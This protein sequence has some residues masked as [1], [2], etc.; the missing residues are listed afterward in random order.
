MVYVL[1]K[2]RHY[3]SG[4]HFN[5]YTYHSSLS[6][7]LNKPLLGGRI[8]IWLLLFQ[9]SDFKVVVKSGK[10]NAGLDHLSN[11]QLPRE[12]VGNIDDNLLDVHLFAVKMV[13]DYFTDIVRFLST[14]MAMLDM[15]VAQKK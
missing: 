11:I 7:L 10:L 12:Y 8:C 15:T 4:S 3:L 6:Y 13:D 1:E 5:M 14:G 2:F 9:E